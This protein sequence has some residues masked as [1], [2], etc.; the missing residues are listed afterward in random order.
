M[1]SPVSHI[2][3]SLMAVLGALVGLYLY[4]QRAGRQKN[5]G[6][7]EQGFGVIAWMRQKLVNWPGERVRRSERWLALGLA[8]FLCIF[9][10]V[11]AV[12]S[13]L[14]AL[15]VV[16]FYLLARHIWLSRNW[17]LGIAGLVLLVG[18]P[19]LAFK[20]VRPL[21]LKIQYARYDLISFISGSAHQGMSDG[22]R[23]AS[24]KAALM[25]GSREPWLGLGVGDVRQ[26]MNRCY[27][28]NFPIVRHDMIV[29]NQFL[30][31]YVAAGITG[32]AMSLFSFLFPL[33]YRRRHASWLLVSFGL[34]FFVSFMVEATLEIQIGTALYLFFIPLAINLA[35]AEK[36]G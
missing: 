13:G 20:T 17:R 9:L 34:I 16:A 8:L 2:R 1:P 3:F 4:S 27:E 28:A 32:V 31:I 15:Y 14:L 24:M 35:G 19:V 36:P 7:P 23:V 18:L 29:H 22:P 12:R 5:E 6:L 33:F 21:Q 26:E 30:F 10:H 25:V 11:F